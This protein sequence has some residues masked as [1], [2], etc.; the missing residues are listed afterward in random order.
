MSRAIR[1]ALSA[2]VAA[3]LA[4]AV[5]AQA[6]ASPSL[7]TQVDEIFSAFT[8]DGPGCAVAVYQNGSVVL[9]KGYGSANL[10][11][12]VP[13]TPSTPF[14]VGSVVE[15]VHRRGDCVAGRRETDRPHRRRAEVR[16]RAGGLRHAD[17][18]RP[19]RA[20]HERAARLVGAGRSR[21]A[22]LRRHLCRPGRARHDGPAARPQLH[23][24]RA[25]CLQQHRLHRAGHRRAARHRQ[26]PARVRGRSDLRPA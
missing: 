17:H 16:A 20:P 26:E 1:L 3:G 22:A 11:Y 24:G 4:A 13:I 12:G 7:A 21:R 14:I 5:S 15:A 18:D 19:S 2:L 9:A 10:E 8:P 25:L 6:P 23:A